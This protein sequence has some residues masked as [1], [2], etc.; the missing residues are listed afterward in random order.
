MLCTSS[1]W[2][3]KQFRFCAYLAY[4]HIKLHIYTKQI[5]LLRKHSGTKSSQT[6][7]EGATYKWLFKI[8]PVLKILQSNVLEIFQRFNLNPSVLKV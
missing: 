7:S 6:M 2:F 3:H 4:Q 8:S 1:E 5:Q